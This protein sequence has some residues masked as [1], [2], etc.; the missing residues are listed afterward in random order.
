M[1]YVCT[2]T[3]NV[4]LSSRQFE[5]NKTKTT[6]NHEHDDP[7]IPQPDLRF[8]RG[9]S[10]ANNRKPKP[11][12]TGPEPNKNTHNSICQ[13]TQWLVHCITLKSMLMNSGPRHSSK[14]EGQDSLCVYPG[15]V[16]QLY[17]NTGLQH[18]PL[19]AYS[20]I[21]LSRETPK[22]ESSPYISTVSRKPWWTKSQVPP[23]QGGRTKMAHR[24]H[25]RPGKNFQ[26]TIANV[27]H[28]PSC[29]GEKCNLQIG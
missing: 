11:T 21:S 1:K 3:G 17:N 6:E 12:K 13:G 7:Q 25:H 24:K 10:E 18:M 27:Q 29:I 20:Q 2:R 26:N 8:A 16:C 15:I 14:H 22:T 19:S 5:T 23:Q 28:T 9:N 4:H